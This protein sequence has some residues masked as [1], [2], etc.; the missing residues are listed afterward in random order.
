MPDVSLP[1]PIFVVSD[2]TGDTAETVVRAALHQ[3]HGYLVHMQVFPNVTERDQLEN[4]IRRAAKER[5]LVAT[6]LVRP[7]MRSAA[8]EFAKQHRVRTVELLGHLLTQMTLFMDIAPEGV[9]GRM[10]QADER[11]FERIEAVEFTVKADDGKEP[12]LMKQADILLLGVSRTS[13]TPLSVFLAHK[14]YKVSNVPIVLDRPLP[15]ILHEIDPNR[16]FALTIDPEALRDIRY[17]R[18]ESMRM[19]GRTNYSDMDYIL[20]ELEWADDLF[21]RHPSWPVID[22][23][24]KAVEE[25]AAT[26]I[27]I[28]GERGLS[29]DTRE[30]GQL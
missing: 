16:I 17:Q 4:L 13:K 26:I 23:T 19:P 5:A 14:G 22:V 21:R 10:H 2:G 9:P 18:M 27:K 30:S 15:S 8:L 20:A 12:R 24:R 7:D 11:Y 25:T 28:L 3:F 6:T 29:S 1:R